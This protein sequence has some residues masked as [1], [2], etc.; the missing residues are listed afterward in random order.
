M[1]A[2]SRFLILQV[3]RSRGRGLADR[4]RGRLPAGTGQ[5]RRELLMAPGRAGR[6]HRRLSP[7]CKFGKSVTLRNRGPDAP[8]GGGGV[9]AGRSA[10]DRTGHAVPSEPCRPCRVRRSLDAARPARH[11]A[12]ARPLPATRTRSLALL[13]LAGEAAG[14][15]H[16]DRGQARY[17]RP[18][19]GPTGR[20]HV[21]AMGG[22]RDREPGP[23]RHRDLGALQLHR[24]RPPDPRSRSAVRGR[25]IASASTNA[26]AGRSRHP[27]DRLPPRTATRTP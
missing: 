14:T 4:Q 7:E 15:G 20:S 6:P 24:G 23:G 11:A 16:P 19:G 3:R 9:P 5:G 25:R 27:M 22:P 21:P 17:L 18:D 12:G 10:D 26:P 2:D 13:E 8:F 1:D